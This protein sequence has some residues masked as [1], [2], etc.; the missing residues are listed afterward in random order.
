MAERTTAWHGFM[1]PKGVER[2]AETW[3]VENIPEDD[4]FAVEANLGCANA[5]DRQ[6]GFIAQGDV[7]ISSFG[8]ADECA[9]V[10]EHKISGSRIGARF[11]V[12]ADKLENGARRGSNLRLCKVSNG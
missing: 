7:A 4:Y 6:A 12:I 5:K 3:D 2:T 10:V 8:V 1:L 9:I 11:F